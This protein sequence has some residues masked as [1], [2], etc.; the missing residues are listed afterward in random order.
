M[1]PN[2]N[3]IDCNSN[4]QESIRSM[5]KQ[6]NDTQMVKCNWFNCYVGYLLITISQSVFYMHTDGLQ[7]NQRICECM[8]CARRHPNEEN[9]SFIIISICQHKLLFETLSVHPLQSSRPVWKMARTFSVNRNG[10]AL[11]QYCHNRTKKQ[12]LQLHFLDSMNFCEHMDVCVWVCVKYIR[13]VINSVSYVDCIY[14]GESACNVK[15]IKADKW[16]TQWMG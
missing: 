7:H 11:L 9:H 13:K 16:L 12:T 14:F 2:G 3:S 10:K 6:H 4:V 5:I 8:L 1:K 15:A